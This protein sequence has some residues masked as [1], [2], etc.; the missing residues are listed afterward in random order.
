MLGTRL[1]FSQTK[2][3]ITL[4]TSYKM[5]GNTGESTVRQM[6]QNVRQMYPQDYAEYLIKAWKRFMDDCFLIWNKKFDFTPFFYMVNNLDPSITF[7]KEEDNKALPFLDIMVIKKK[8][9]Q[10]HRNRH[11]L[12]TH[13]L[14]Q[15]PR[16]PQLS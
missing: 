16:F 7:T 10:Y 4:T 8:S 2:L 3:K 6:Y 13:Q 12:Q 9:R 5:C 15:I 14:T 1:S 11:L